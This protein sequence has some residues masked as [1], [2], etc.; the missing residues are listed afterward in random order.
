MRKTRL[1]TVLAIAATVAGLGWWKWTNRSESPK[2]PGSEAL[3]TGGRLVVTYRSEPRTFNRLV[4]PQQ[5]EELVT[6]LTQATLVRLDRAT[7]RLEPR[8]AREWSASPDGLTW[9]LQLL[10]DVTFSDG[11]PFTSADVIFSFQALFDTRVKSEIASSLLIAG[12]PPQ[13]RALDASTVV[14]VL[15]SPYGPGL[16]LLDAVPILPRHKLAAALEAGTFRDA[17]SVKTPLSEIVGL[18]PFVIREYVAGQRLVFERNPR[19]WR[20]DE[21]GR[22][23]PYL[24]AIDLQ[25]LPDQ[26][27][28]VLRLQ[29]GDVDL[30]SNQVRF[31]DLASLKTLESQG[32]VALHDAGV[33]IAPD[34]MWFNLDPA[35]KTAR[36]RPWLQRDEF[37]HAISAAVDRQALVDTVFLGEAVLIGGPITPGH[38]GWF[39]P[40][41]LRPAFNPEAATR[42]LS[43]IDLSD[44]NGDGLLDD[45]QG[46]TARFSLL[47]QKGHT[48]RERSAAMVQEHLRR[49]GLQVDVVPLEVRSMIEAWGKGEYDA[50]Y[51]AIEFDSFDPARHLDFWLSSGAF[52][53]WHPRQTAPATAWEGRIDELMKQQAATLDEPERRRLFTD[54]QRVLAEHEPVLYFA[55]PK[56]ILATNARVR[57][58]TPSVLAPNLLWNAER[59]SV[60]GAA[61]ARR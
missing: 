10:E 60:S 22:A 7:G 46:Q 4:A 19:F 17:W 20:R 6:R 56:V 13:V 59:M 30:I 55:A 11:A 44:R 33:S 61:V 29:A 42:L 50:I 34:M 3:E 5:A 15:P 52:H 57:G 8:L 32:R 2:N 23:L 51:F 16:S 49:I 12:K 45:S 31:E 53:F 43:S 41:L 47:T 14:V 39:V 38:R 28:E 58:V 36:T 21:Q 25:F 24:D 18:G 37:R 27:A 35:A 54:A 40:E 48:V 1:I 9:T 26:N